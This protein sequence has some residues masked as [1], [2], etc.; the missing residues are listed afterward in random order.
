MLAGLT[1]VLVLKERV[2]RRA[3]GPVPGSD[4]G[5]LAESAGVP[6]C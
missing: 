3:S 2:E 6:D 1:N 5:L 4:E